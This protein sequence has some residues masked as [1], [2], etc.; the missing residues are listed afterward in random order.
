M[1][2]ILPIEIYNRFSL[3]K[4]AFVDMNWGGGSSAPHPGNSNPDHLYMTGRTLQRYSY[5]KM[6]E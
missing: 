6:K 2:E 3:K 5:D 4:W 1:F